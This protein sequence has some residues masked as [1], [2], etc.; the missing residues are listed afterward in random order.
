MNEQRTGVSS[1]PARVSQEAKN[2]TVSVMKRLEGMELLTNDSFRG[3]IE[4][5]YTQGAADLQIIMQSAGKLLTEVKAVF[6][7]ICNGDTSVQ[8]AAK[9]AELLQ[10]YESIVGVTPHVNDLKA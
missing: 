6:R 7:S 5:A 10:G 4:Q 8:T 2:Y 9:Y 3:V 1:I